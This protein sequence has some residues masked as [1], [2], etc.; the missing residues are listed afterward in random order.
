MRCLS[1]N[2]GLTDLEAS[3]K[4]KGTKKYIDLCTSCFYE[5]RQ[6]FVHNYIYDE[7]INS[8]VIEFIEEEEEENNVPWTSW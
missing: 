4:Y 6:E 2:K 3:K 8:V 7:G 5:V 1:C